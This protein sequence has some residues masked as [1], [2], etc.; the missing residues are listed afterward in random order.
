M[1]DRL[2]PKRAHKD[3]KMLWNDEGL[4]FAKYVHRYREWVKPWDQE[5]YPHLY[6]WPIDSVLVNKTKEFID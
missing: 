6:I 2:H 3:L 4:G 5:E 1:P